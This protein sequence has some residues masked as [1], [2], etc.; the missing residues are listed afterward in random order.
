MKIAFRN[1]LLTLRRYKAASFLNWVG[2]TFAFAACYAIL[3]QV[4]WELTFNHSLPAH[5]RSYLAVEHI[6]LFG[7]GFQSQMSHPSIRAAIAESPEIESFAYIDPWLPPRDIDFVHSHWI[8]RATGREEIHVQASNRDLSPYVVTETYFDFFG[9]KACKG[10]LSAIRRPDAAAISR[11]LAEQ[12][13]V[14]VGTLIYLCQKQPVEP[15]EVVAIFEDPA[16]NSSVHDLHILLTHQGRGRDLQS[17][18]Y[19]CMTTFFL[20]FREGADTQPFLD[21]WT[22]RTKKESPFCNRGEPEHRLVPV[23]EIYYSDFITDS[24]DHGKRSSTLI[25]I[26]IALLIVL[27]ALINFVNFFFAMIPV[28]VKMVNIAKVFGASA[29]EMRF[30]FLFESLAFVLLGM[31]GAAYLLLSFSRSLLPELFPHTLSPTANGPVIAVML[32]GAAAAVLAVT[33]W[34]IRYITSFP[35]SMAAQG[36]VGSPKGRHLRVALIFLQF[37]IA[38]PLIAMTL[39][40]WGQSR[41]MQRHD[42]GFD[43]ENLYRAELPE[44]MRTRSVNLFSEQLAAMPEIRCHSF[45]SSVIPYSDKRHSK[46]VIQTESRRMEFIVISGDTAMLRVFGIP[47]LEGRDF[48]AGD[49]QFGGEEKFIVNAASTR[50][51]GFDWQTDLKGSIGVCRDAHFGS[52]RFSIPPICFTFPASGQGAYWYNYLFFRVHP[53]TDIE[54]LQEKI[55]AAARAQNAEVMPTD[56]SVQR[57]TDLIAQLYAD[58]QHEALLLTGY[59]LLAVLLS[60]M[61]VFGLVLFE[62]LYRRREVAIRKVNGATTGEI[63]RMFNRQYIWIVAGCFAIAGPASYWMAER[64]LSNFAYRM[65]HFVW[66]IGLAFLLVLAITVLTVTVRSWRAA[67]T[68]PVEC[69]KR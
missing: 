28:R 62:T 61:G 66:M 17:D 52:M 4:Y 45:T 32:L 58:E 12:W 5:E 50:Q 46:F 34:P 48:T 30:S 60:L 36:V 13:N 37:V 23:R 24:R 22:L 51:D 6:P 39:I 10:D 3:S 29:G 31:G 20:R 15:V 16:E 54:A 63:L 53:Q 11:S 67:N 49:M 26:G 35:P 47:I 57:M 56:I 33:L 42:P 7:D 69:M 25:Q 1:L 64:W 38:I 14:D 68:N 27:I 44:V 40:M 21:R 41:Y 65:P 59:S 9:I 19:G 18:R 55:R 2:L 8:N 43:A